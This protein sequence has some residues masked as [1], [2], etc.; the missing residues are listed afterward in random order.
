MTK[1][2]RSLSGHERHCCY[3]NLHGS[4]QAEGRFANVS[5]VSGLDLDDDGRGLAFVDW[6]QDGDQDLLISNRNAPRI[7]FM[8]ND[9]INENHFVAVRLIGN[10]TTTNRDAIGA[11]VEVVLQ[12]ENT[13]EKKLNPATDKPS[14]TAIGP[15]LPKPLVK[16]LRAGEGYVSQNSR[17]IHF[18]LGRSKQIQK[19]VIYWPGG[20]AEDFSPIQIDQYYEL[21]QGTGKPQLRK[22]DRPTKPLERKRP[23]IA[24]ATQKAR[25]PLLTPLPMPKISYTL[26][27]HETETLS[28]NQGKAVLI[29]LWASWCQPCVQELHEFTT[30]AAEIRGANVEI[31]A[32]S[33]DGVGSDET[34]PAISKQLIKKMGFPFPAG[35]ATPQLIDMLQ[36]IHNLTI[37]L[38][39]PLPVPSSFLVDAN[40]DLTVIYKGPISVEQL[41]ADIKYS[42]L[43]RKQQLEQTSGLSGK[44][45]EHP[46]VQQLMNRDDARSLFDTVRITQTVD[47]RTAKRTYEEILRLDP[48]FAQAHSKL[49][50]I[51]LQLN[52]IDEAKKHFRKALVIDPNLSAALYNLGAI[53]A[54]A[55]DLSTAED[56]FR[57]LE[58]G[59]PDSVQAVFNL[60][61]VFLNQ[62]KYDD[63]KV[64]LDKA[65]KLSPTN[66]NIIYNRGKVNAALNNHENAIL[67][68][69]TA[70]EQQPTWLAAYK[71]RA[72]SA[73]KLK[74]YDVA[75][76]DYTSAIE[77][78]PQDANLYFNRGQILQIFGR[79]KKALEDYNVAIRLDP[80]RAMAYNNKAW[81]LATCVNAEM[82][83][84]DQ[85]LA[86]A[87]RAF[88][89]AKDP[90]RYDV[91]DTLAAAYA[92]ATQYEKAVEWQ[93][94]AIERAPENA[95]PPLAER[96]KL[97][98]SGKPY[99][100]NPSLPVTGAPKRPS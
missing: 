87:K 22:N 9:S 34:D 58:E 18:G 81:I 19:V 13:S 10:G 32:L 38:Q 88:D 31:V 1:Q 44:I 33:V 57:K 20:K 64:Y 46:R 7:R 69:S 6:D 100:A 93:L 42:D 40:G 43:N 62:Y 98:Q 5:A 53:A 83:N 97:Y 80:D 95:K 35:Q 36:K 76:D 86:S 45:I 48:D 61:M 79:I 60:G 59:S 25:A 66:T 96:L 15:T 56:Y 12:K 72:K 78:A 89:L 37:P 73:V 68:Y 91:L 23:S 21:K 27:D 94:K 16:T 2:G 70:L 74:K 3:L 63:A 65:H 49:G 8:R 67:D 26:F 29:N 77:L 24:S 75:I 14:V 52:E 4:S 41:L 55:G 84:G 11:R 39:L 85:A 30:H 82:R 92:E 71:N 17:W 90:K 54:R 47:P 28:F 51:C 50:I 99:R